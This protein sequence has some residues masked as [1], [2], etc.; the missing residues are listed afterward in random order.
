MH[1]EC[2]VICNYESC[3]PHIFTSWKSHKHKKLVSLCEQNYYEPVV[4][5]FCVHSKFLFSNILNKNFDRVV[6]IYC[7]D[8]SGKKGSFCK[9]IIG[10]LPATFS[11]IFVLS[12]ILHFFKNV[13]LQLWWSEFESR[14]NLHNLICKIVD[15]KTTT[16]PR[17]AARFKPEVKPRSKL[18]NCPA[19]QEQHK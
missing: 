16:G 3:R 2:P 14:W 19:Q 4:A 8:K 9:K 11:W 6:L 18:T 15:N 7:L 12:S 10:T 17:F 1:H 5:N 13:C